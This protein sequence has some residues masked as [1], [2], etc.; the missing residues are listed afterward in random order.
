MR[1][2]TSE[3]LSLNHELHGI[4]KVQ[5]EKQEVIA[6]GLLRQKTSPMLK[7]YLHRLSRFIQAEVETINKLRDELNKT[8][9]EGRNE[10]DKTSPDVIKEFSSRVREIMDTEI[11][12]D[13]KVFW[14]N[15]DMVEVMRLEKEMSSDEY[16]PV[17]FNLIGV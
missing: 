10:E 2:K 11:E 4:V 16:Y 1:L 13:T 6:S 7:M 9:W 5:G 3:I 15:V 17:F 12:V 8:F 14:G